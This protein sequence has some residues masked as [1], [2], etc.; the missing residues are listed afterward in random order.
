[1]FL[2]DMLDKVEPHFEK[3]GRLEDYY[4]VFEMVDTIFYTPGE[5]TA[6]ASHVRDAIDLKRL[7]VTVWLCAFL[8]MF[9]GMYYVGLQANIAMD[10][11]GVESLAGW[12]GWIVEL[13][14]GYDANSW[15]D[16]IIY[17]AVFYVPIY[18][19]TFAVGG[20]WEVFFALKRGHEINEGFFVTSILFSLI[21]P[22][23]IPLWQVVLGISFGVVIGKE[24]FGGTGK[25]FLNP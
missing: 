7:M 9:A 15:W 17:G 1:M 11:M 22:A 14:A 16:C 25:N 18:F 6:S 4:V 12:R 13:I 21:V 20:L 10:Q 5:V 19:V 3:G 23:T 24:I 8:P 2:R